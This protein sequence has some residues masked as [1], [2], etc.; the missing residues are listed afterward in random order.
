MTLLVPPKDPDW[1]LWNGARTG[2]DGAVGIFGADE[3][4][5]NRALRTVLA[6]G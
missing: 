5:G 1:E 2:L 4:S 3:V 6:Q